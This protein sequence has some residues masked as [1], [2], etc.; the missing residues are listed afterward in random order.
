MELRNCGSSDLKLSA[1]GVGCWSFGGGE[2]WGE[3]AQ[4]DADQVVRRAVDLGITYFDTAESYNEGR[5]ESSLGRAIRG[6]PRDRIVIGT[7][8][9]PSN[10]AP[11]VLPRH[12]EDSLKRLGT[13]YI[14]LYMVHW[15]ITP[16]SI[17]HFKEQQTDCPSVQETFTA[18]RR[19]Q[20]QGK[21]RYIGVSN[22]AA[23]KLREALD[24]GTMIV[25]DQLPYSLVAR[26]I[27]HEILP[28]CRELGIGVVGYM[29]LWQGL[30][31]ER[32]AGL[33]ELPVW[34]RRTRHF[35]A[36]KNELA[37][38]GEGGAEEET[39]QAVLAVRTIARELGRSTAEVALRWTLQG[40][41][42]SCVLAGA[43][44]RQQLEANVEAA[45]ERLSEEVVQRLAAE[46][47]ALKK[48]L[49]PSCDYFEGTANDRTR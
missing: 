3:Q 49:G 15:P 1:L 23:P 46:T 39:W 33:D 2:Y 37:R 34:R 43:R 41:G 22:F 10:V 31:T 25:V 6:I 47:E 35:D 44:S 30:L 18:L 9:S 24:T 5:S 7:K 29:P 27:E 12:C 20:E 21:V 14:D 26:A 13:E 4:A 40:P 32:Y 17:G 45:G 19:L 8:I 38:H 16:H 48:K 36:R 11:D 42:I 28:Q